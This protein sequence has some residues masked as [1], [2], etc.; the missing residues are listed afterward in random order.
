MKQSHKKN[1]MFCILATFCMTQQMQPCS[2]S[3]N[4]EESCFAATWETI[5]GLF[6]KKPSTT[7]PN[8]AVSQTSKNNERPILTKKIP[9]A[10][11]TKQP[12]LHDN[13][14]QVQDPILVSPNAQ[15]LVAAVSI[16]A[17]TSVSVAIDVPLNRSLSDSSFDDCSGE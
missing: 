15:Q 17:Q 10:S 8:V 13:C 12:A 6:I 7:W 11:M 16:D 14:L 9:A 1:L 2:S 4:E 3:S 5:I